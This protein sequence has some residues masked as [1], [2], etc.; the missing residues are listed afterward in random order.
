MSYIKGKIKK[1]IYHNNESGYSVALF[2]IKET[3][4]L[5]VKDKV[6]KTI[7][8]TGV[9]TEVNVDIPLILHGEYKKNEKFGMQYVVENSEIEMPTTKNA[10]VEFLASSFIDGCGEKT[11]KKIVD[12]FGE[13]TLEV[14]KENKNNLLSVE[15]ITELR[16]AKIYNSLANYNKS[17][18]VILKLQNLGFSIEECSRIYNHFKNEIDLI[19]GDGF[20]NLKEVID[21]HKLDNIYIANFGADNDIRTYACILESMQILSNTL[22]DTYYS[23][24]DIRKVLIREFNIEISEEAL[25]ECLSY[26]IEQ[27]EVI[28][29]GKSIYL[30]KYYEKEVNVARCLHL[31][32]SFKPMQIK[33]IDERLEKLEKRIGFTYNEEQKKAIK[34]ALNNNITIISGGPGTGKTTIINAIVKLYIEEKR[35]GPADIIESIALLAPTGRASKK[36]S[37]STNLPAYTIHRYLKW[38]KDS[39]DF[40]YNEYNK[41]TQELIIV[42][43]VSMIDIDLFNALLNG[44]NSKIKL[45]LVGD[46]F[47][48]PS[49]GAGLVLNDLIESDYFNYVPL[50][51]IYRQSDNSYIP[52]LAREI[53]NNDLS[54]ELLEKKD[55]YSF[56]PTSNSQIKSMIEQIIKISLQKGINERNM[57]ILAPMYKGENGIDNLNVILQNIYNPPKDNLDEIMYMDTIFR[58]NDKVLQLVND[59]DHNVFNGD[60]GYITSIRNGKITIDFEGNNVEYEKKDLKEI[61]HA[62][63]ITIHKS[64]GSEFDHVIMPISNSY[65]KMLYNKL[66]YTGVSRAKKSL[67]IVGDV[68][69][70][71]MA[72]SNNY[73]SNRKTDLKNKI[74]SVYNKEY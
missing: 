63:A 58:V 48:L 74:I 4:D 44:I 69:A 9:F 24:E 49:V 7:T 26:L 50:N 45:I 20:Y 37:S 25:R 12:K 47:Q 42:D 54:E 32:D 66:I 5:D 72:V 52:Y 35:L 2:R 56:F 62:Y 28:I 16:A 65:Y 68:K 15:G 53:K 33:D 64:Q 23:E 34:S 39:N 41:T 60:I 61:K 19:M 70:F 71:V 59:L 43:E 67:T 27:D 14:I 11:A 40:Y 36:M 46:T 18:D 21:F 1:I 51:Q 30:K 13:E 29:V 17:S 55:D 10:I 73:S 22:G 31:I 3:D 6:N 8:I 38:Y 57:Q